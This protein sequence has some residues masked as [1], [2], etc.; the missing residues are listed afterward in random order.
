MHRA[1]AACLTAVEREFLQLRNRPL[2]LDARRVIGREWG[3]EG[4]AD[5]LELKSIQG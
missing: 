2:T 3:E 4:L 5:F 1:H